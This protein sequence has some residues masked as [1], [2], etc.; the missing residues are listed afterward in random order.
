MKKCRIYRN[1]KRSILVGSCD[2]IKRKENTR[3]VIYALLDQPYHSWHW[4]NTLSICSKMLC[5]VTLGRRLWAGNT[6]LYLW[7]CAEECK[8]QVVQRGRW[9]NLTMFLLLFTGKDEKG[10]CHRENFLRTLRHVYMGLRRRWDLKH[11]HI[12]LYML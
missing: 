4:I 2:Y 8:C 12:I 5:D 9:L 11:T 3:R 10:I 7:L 1:V 6:H